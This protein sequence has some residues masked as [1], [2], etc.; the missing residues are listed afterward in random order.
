[1]QPGYLI[2]YIGLLLDRNNFADAE[3]WL[4]TLEKM[5]PNSF[6]VLR[7]R[8]ECLARRGEFKAAVE[9]ITGYLDKPDPNR[10]QQIYNVA[11][12]VESIAA[13]AK[14]SNQD[15]LAAS[16]ESKAEALY[17]SL[18]SKK[19]SL[20]GD[21]AYAVFLAGQ[22]R[23]GEALDVLQQTLDASDRLALF[24]RTA[25]IIFSSHAATP[26][27]LEQLERIVV[28]GAVKYGR[29]TNLLLLQ[30]LVYDE[31]HQ[32][33]KSRDI[34]HEVL[35]KEPR[36][37]QALN[38]LGV[39]MAYNGENLDEALSRVNQAMAVTGPLPA[40]L[41][42]R[43]VVYLMRHEPD[44]ALEDLNTAIGENVSP[45]LYFHKAW[46]LSL[47]DRKSDAAEAFVEARN[48]GLD[49]KHL[50]QQEIAIYDRL[51]DMQ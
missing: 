11:V 30:A 43:A 34:Y 5:T 17:S 16:F 4:T 18:R 23:I 20:D 39:N 42:S 32:Y 41:D 28:A 13:R 36:N 3:Q 33:A 26:A 37:F 27:Q 45:E 22:K 47:L 25:G 15:A 35:A 49:A 2:F 7:L 12:V 48:K 8:A 9:L 1:V 40:M 19:V 44:K 24:H 31:Q 14:A 29:P 50:A 51:K 6:D 21:Y 10:G 38:N 46:A